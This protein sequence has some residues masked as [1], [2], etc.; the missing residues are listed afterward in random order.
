MRDAGDLYRMKA[1]EVMCSGHFIGDSDVRYEG[2]GESGNILSHWMDG[3]PLLN[4]GGL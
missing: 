2:R 3:L 4:C 1:V